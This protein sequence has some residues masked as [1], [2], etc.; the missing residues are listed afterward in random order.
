MS[1]YMIDALPLGF[2]PRKSVSL[3]DSRGC[4]LCFGICRH[5]SVMSVVGNISYSSPWGF[6]L[7]T[8]RDRTWKLPLSIIV[9]YYGGACHPATPIVPRSYRSI[10]KIQSICSLS[11]NVFTTDSSLLKI[12]I[13][14]IHSVLYHLLLPVRSPGA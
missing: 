10:I 7:Q 2:S 4:C 8:G 14:F 13:T 6:N 12:N 9:Y 5:F 3:D 11:N 1:L